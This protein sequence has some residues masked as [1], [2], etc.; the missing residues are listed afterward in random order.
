MFDRTLNKPQNKK[1]RDYTTQKLKFSITHFFSKCEQIRRKL[2]IWS[3][4]LKKL[5][6]E[7]FIFCAVQNTASF[8]GWLEC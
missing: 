6:I 1:N 2:R 7:N 4:L 3:H 5:L 8:K